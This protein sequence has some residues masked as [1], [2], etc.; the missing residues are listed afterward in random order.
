MHVWVGFLI[1]DVRLFSVVN[2]ILCVDQ[3]PDS[4]DFDLI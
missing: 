4:T 2:Q 3:V 1:N